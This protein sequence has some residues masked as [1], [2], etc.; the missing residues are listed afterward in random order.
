MAHFTI[1]RPPSLTHF[2]PVIP[3]S[4]HERAAC[5]LYPA[6]GGEPAPVPDSDAAAENGGPGAGEQTDGGP[7][8]AEVFAAH[9]VGGRREPPAD[10]WLA[11]DWGKEEWFY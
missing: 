8:V 1:T 4:P 7:W 11:D 9:K 10:V 5:Y 3:P 6:V 2:A